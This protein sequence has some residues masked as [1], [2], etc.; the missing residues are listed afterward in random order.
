MN[1]NLLFDFT[2]NKENNSIHVKREFA[3]GLEL[4]WDCWTKAEL[5]EQWWAPKPWRAETKSMDFREGGRWLYAMVSPKNEYFWSR[6]DYI[7]IETQKKFSAQDGFGDENVNLNPDF[8]RSIWNKVF[9]EGAG[10]TTV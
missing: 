7:K 8:P 9:Q 6:V 10:T 5:L 2:V 4:V 3:A 1:T